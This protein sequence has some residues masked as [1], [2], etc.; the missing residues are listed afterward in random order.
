MY[1]KTCLAPSSHYSASSCSSYF[2]VLLGLLVL[3][4]VVLIVLLS[5]CFIV[6][7]LV[8]FDFYVSGMQCAL[9]RDSVVVYISFHLFGVMCVTCVCYVRI[10]YSDSSA[11]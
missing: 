3:R 9:M 10:N 5:S 7:I 1:R 8:L 6:L 2:R 11:I 4:G